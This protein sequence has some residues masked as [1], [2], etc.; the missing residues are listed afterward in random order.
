MKTRNYD[1]VI[2]GGGPGGMAAAISAQKNGIDSVL[3][4]ERN[5]FLGG[6]LN[7]CIHTGFGLTYYGEDL[8]G[9][10]YADRFIKMIDDRKIEFM[11]DATVLSI[12]ANKCIEVAS[13]ELGYLHIQAKAIVLA[14]G[15]RERPAG[16]MQIYGTRPSGIMTA[17][18]AQKLLNIDGLNIG[19]EVVILGSGD[20]GLIMARRLTLEGAKVLAVVEK[21]AR[22]S[23]LARNIV[24]CLDDFDIP[25]LLSMTVTEIFGEHRI[26]GLSLAPVE[27]GGSVRW[28]ENRKIPCDTL[29]I[30]AGLI[31]ENELSLTAG[32]LLEA[33]NGGAKVNENKETTVEGIF[34]CGNVVRVHETADEVTVEGEKA[35][36]SA[37][38]Y[39]RK[40]VDDFF[41]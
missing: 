22:P 32:I 35:G 36:E 20:I 29:L 37:A 9:P 12:T 19:Q 1:I 28:Q 10:E 23:G 17:G 7:Q 39:V 14:M 41:K 38:L 3:I 26:E 34:A 5:L 16:A 40:K 18:A 27:A 31:P 4:I 8:T 24:Q 25:L 33:T 13:K 6:I 2:I 11:L 30:A 21:E 15:C